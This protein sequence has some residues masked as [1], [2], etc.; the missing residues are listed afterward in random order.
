MKL[1]KTA[2]KLTKG[3]VVLLAVTVL[4]ILTGA[5]AYWSFRV[6]GNYEN[7]Y[8]TWRQD[9]G[10]DIDAALQLSTASSDDRLKKITALEEVTTT[11]SDKQSICD[12]S[13]V[14]AWQRGIGGLASRTDTCSEIMDVTTAY[15]D[16]LNGVLAYLK[17]EREIASI[18]DATATN[19]KQTEKTWDTQLAAWTKA[20]GDIGNVQAPEEFTST[21]EYAL[22]YAKK[23]E[24][25]WR[26]VIAAHKAQNKSKYLKAYADLVSAHEML[27]TLA[28]KSQDGFTAITK[29]LQVQYDALQ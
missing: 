22:K 7:S 26:G 10:Q 20:V 9:I 12:M 17:A 8:T 5:Y 13:G 18:I 25:T 23:M 4:L 24:S 1:R 27:A 19:S 16:S 3:R 21:K 28:S 29:N 15:R 6:W 14:F 11:I 2:F